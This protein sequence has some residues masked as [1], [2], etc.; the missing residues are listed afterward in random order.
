MTSA[1]LITPRGESGFL[2]TFQDV[3]ELKKR[4]R[5]A[6]VQQRL[7]AVGE[8]AAGIAHEI[9]NPL[10]SMAGSIQILRDEL[11]LTEEQSQLMNI[12]LRESDRLNETIRNF[13]AFARPQRAAMADLDVGRIVADAARLL[14]NNA[15]VTERHAI[16]VDVPDTPVTL[17]ADEA[18]IRQ[19]IWN[20]A[21][22]GLRAMPEGGTLRLAARGNEDDRHEVVIAVQDDGVGIAPEELDG[23]FQPFRGGFAR[24]TGL[25]LSIVHRIATDYGGEVRVASQKGKGTTV[26]VALPAAPAASAI[27]RLAAGGKTGVA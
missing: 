22:N 13:L 9:R 18:Q 19:I 10:A 27:E 12:V 11:A 21:T 17:R 4:D 6:R 25:G 20:L 5:E 26:E 15:D 7:A 8:M 2:Y 16:V 14:Q 1:P 3:T 23:I 24:G